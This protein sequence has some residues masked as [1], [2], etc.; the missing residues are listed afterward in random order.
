V[1]WNKEKKKK[2]Y[3]SINLLLYVFLESNKMEKGEKQNVKR[4][5]FECLQNER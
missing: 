2:G 4:N 5:Y 3:M 1:G